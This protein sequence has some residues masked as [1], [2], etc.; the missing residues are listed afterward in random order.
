[1]DGMNSD[2]TWLIVSTPTTLI[3]AVT[4]RTS[5]EKGMAARFRFCA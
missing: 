5:S 3:I 1:M 4:A 2:E